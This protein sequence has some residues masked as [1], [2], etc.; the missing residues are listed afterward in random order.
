MGMRRA[1]DMAEDHAR[2]DHVVDIAAAA[3]QQP[4]ILEA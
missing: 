3:A 1:Q 2:Q 4:G